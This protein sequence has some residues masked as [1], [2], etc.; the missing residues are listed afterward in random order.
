ML[1]ANYVC[2]VDELFRTGMSTMSKIPDADHINNLMNDTLEL[3]EHKKSIA[4]SGK[5]DR[6]IFFDKS[7]IATNNIQDTKFLSQSF[8]A[9]PAP[10]NRYTYLLLPDE[11]EESLSKTYIPANRFNQTFRDRLNKFGFNTKIYRKM[12]ILMR[13]NLNMVKFD[14]SKS[15]A[16]LKSCNFCHKKW[17]RREKFYGLVKGFA[18]FNH[19]FREAQPFPIM[20]VIV[21]TDYDY[22]QATNAMNRIIQD[23]KKLLNI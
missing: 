18:M 22:M 14:T 4:R 16:Y 20:K 23:T 3:L 2:L 10:H 5:F 11:V 1:S 15:F 7:F 13:K 8:V 9:D 19:L 21:P 12:F 6:T 17:D